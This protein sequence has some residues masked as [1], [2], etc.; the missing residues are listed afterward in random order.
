MCGSKGIEGGDGVQ[1][2]DGHDE[3]KATGVHD[4]S[5]GTPMLNQLVRQDRHS[6]YVVYRQ[7][8]D[9]H[10]GWCSMQY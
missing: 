8:F 10:L 4:E 7:V 1:V 5:T 3:A 2:F 9:R 6:I